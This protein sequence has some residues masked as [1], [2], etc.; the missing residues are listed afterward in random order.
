[1]RCWLAFGAIFCAQPPVFASTTQKKDRQLAVTNLC[2]IYE[3]LSKSEYDAVLAFK[4]F[5]NERLVRSGAL[6]ETY[7]FG[8]V[9]GAGVQA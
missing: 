4:R 1:M 9:T 8:S 2:P 7:L 3:T 6:L 5:L